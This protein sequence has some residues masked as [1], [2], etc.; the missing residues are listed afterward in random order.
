M[1]IEI[2]HYIPEYAQ[3]FKD[4]NEAW[5]NKYF[6]LEEE[7]I[8]TL[9]HP[10]YIIEQGGYIFVA[11]RDLEPVGVCALRKTD[12]NTDEF[13][14]MAVAESGE[15][16]GSGRKLD[17]AAIAKA[18]QSGAKKI[19]LEG[20]TRLEASMHLYKKLG[21]KKTPETSSSFKRV[22]IVMEMEMES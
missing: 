16:L 3:A 10:E 19:Y 9:N 11:L 4:L 6:E 12:N 18:K 21:F 22:N 5:I 20:N 14:K 2:V 8:Y 15:G 7:D 1:S 17:E 13:S